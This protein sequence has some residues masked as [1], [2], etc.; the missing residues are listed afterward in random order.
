MGAH[1]FIMAVIIY[2]FFHR[3]RYE[4]LR[5]VSPF[6]ELSQITSI[7]RMLENIED[8]GNAAPR[9]Q[10]CNRARARR[11]LRYD[12]SIFATPIPLSCIPD[13]RANVFPRKGG[14]R[15]AGIVPGLVIG[16]RW[17]GVGGPRR[18]YF[19][20]HALRSID[21]TSDE[22]ARAIRDRR[23][24]FRPVHVRQGCVGRSMPFDTKCK[25][26]QDCTGTDSRPTRQGAKAAT[27]L[28]KLFLVVPSQSRVK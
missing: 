25:V 7:N 16:C 19:N 21:R 4:I 10:P 26:I 28:F 11:L 17:L 13:R 20:Q 3:K 15:H 12:P 9:Y 14:R 5:T 23:D 24:R 2:H 6:P 8:V 18:T 27:I 1:I 22:Q